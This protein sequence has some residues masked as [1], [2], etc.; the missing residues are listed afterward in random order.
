MCLS[1]CKYAQIIRV[2]IRKSEGCIETVFTEHAN[3]MK[4]EIHGEPIVVIA[5]RLGSFTHSFAHIISVRSL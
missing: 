1:A 3:E 4:V 2:L 5:Q